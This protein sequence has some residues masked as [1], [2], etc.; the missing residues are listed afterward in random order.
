[1]NA[2]DTV[3]FE[4]FYGTVYARTYYNG[5]WGNPCRLILKIPVVNTPT[6]TVDSKGYATIRTTTPRTRIYYTTDGTT[7]SMTNGK[8][9]SSPY[10]R[11]YV[12]KGKT[13]KA[14]AVR[15]CFTHSKVGTG[16]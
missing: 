11:V 5:E 2:G 12:G 7:P 6:V 8:M 15:S 16:K 3:L 9:V 10:V 1:M 13:V 14:I 4:D